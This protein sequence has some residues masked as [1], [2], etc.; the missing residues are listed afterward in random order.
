MAIPDFVIN[1][2]PEIAKEFCKILD[3]SKKWIRENPN[4]AMNIVANSVQQKIE[5]VELAWQKHNWSATINE[6][7]IQDIQNKADFLSEAKVTRN[8][9]RVD[10]K[11][12][13]IFECQN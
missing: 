10:V 8:N 3:E 13:L 9:N 7:L 5:V 6:P 4:K 11:K 1:E 2:N 12:N